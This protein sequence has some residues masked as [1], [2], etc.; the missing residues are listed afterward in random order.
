MN[1]CPIAGMIRFQVDFKHC[2]ALHSS[3]IIPKD[4]VE[5]AKL[6][7]NWSHGHCETKIMKHL[8]L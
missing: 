8:A 6:R 3:Q 1:I 4:F 5:V 2:E 7:Q